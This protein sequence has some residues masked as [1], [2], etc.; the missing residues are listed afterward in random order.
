MAVQRTFETKLTRYNSV[1]KKERERYGIDAVEHYLSEETKKKVNDREEYLKT[2]S[3]FKCE[4]DK[5]YRMHVWRNWKSRI[6][7][8]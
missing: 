5:F 6:S 1:L 4:L 8:R 3:Q 7:N 2:S